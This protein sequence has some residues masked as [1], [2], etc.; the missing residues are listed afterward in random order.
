M[1]LAGLMA[2]TGPC[3]APLRRAESPPGAGAV[4]GCRSGLGQHSY[5]SG[6]AASSSWHCL[7]S[8]AVSSGTKLFNGGKF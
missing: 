2:F 4:P 5:R 3:T 6:R 8:R 1:S 7:S